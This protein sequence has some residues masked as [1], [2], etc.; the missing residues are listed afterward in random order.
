MSVTAVGELPLPERL[1][2]PKRFFG[3]SSDVR[4]GIG[5]RGLDRNL[6]SGNQE[7]E[8]WLFRSPSA[9]NIASAKW[10][11]CIN[12]SGSCC[13]REIPNFCIL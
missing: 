3:A 9:Q 11:I 1:R 4:L 12:Y 2:R 10:A 5:R 7:L 13:G 6:L 8:G